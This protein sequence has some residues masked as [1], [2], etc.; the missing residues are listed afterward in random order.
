MATLMLLGGSRP[1][2]MDLDIYILGYFNWSLKPLVVLV[3]FNKSTPTQLLETRI[4]Y[5]QIE[6]IM[7]DVSL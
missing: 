2:Q 7:L 6:K 4:T 3:D 5:R 1:T